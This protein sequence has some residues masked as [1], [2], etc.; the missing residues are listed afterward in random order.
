MSRLDPTVAQHL[1]AC[2]CSLD[3]SGVSSIS[4]DVAMAFSGFDGT[5]DFSGLTDV[6]DSA[7]YLSQ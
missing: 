2:N 1:A 5:L 7:K 4:P 6:S 3:L